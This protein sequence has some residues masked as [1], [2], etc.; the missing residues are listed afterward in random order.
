MEVVE[1]SSET[2]KE[3]KGR[4][5]S[6]VRNFEVGED[7]ER[8]LIVFPTCQKE[9]SSYLCLSVTSKIRTMCM[10]FVVFLS[11]SLRSQRPP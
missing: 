6:I 8:K 7:V 5:I 9:P 11:T 4:Y 1:E 10:S 3:T 2:Y